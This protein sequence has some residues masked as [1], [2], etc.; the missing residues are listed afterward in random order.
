MRPIDR[1]AMQRLFT[2]RGEA[3]L[4]AALRRRPLIA[5]DFDGTLAPIVA[6]PELA[7]IPA[8]VAARLSWLAAR[9]PV[10]IITGRAVADVRPRLHFTPRYIVG[11]HGAE[12]EEGAP[13]LALARALDPLRER[14]LA[15][16]AALALAGIRVEDK[17]LSIALHYRLARD[18]DAARA[19]IDDIVGALPSTVSLFAG[20]LVVNAIASG[21][22]D[23]ADA[24]RGLVARSGAACAIFAGDDVNDEP[25]FETAPPSWLT[26][27]VGCDQPGSRARYFI[28]STHEMALLLD[29]MLAGL[30]GPAPAG[31]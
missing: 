29:R 24:L 3:A 2:K 28:D 16:A 19:L 6:Q 18:R 26:I 8:P 1:A 15:R 22:P 27:R 17:G 25:V 21:A 10:A 11:N 31:A 4:A 9:V 20:K 14:V 12:P 13:A 23:K 5:F 7:H 30:P